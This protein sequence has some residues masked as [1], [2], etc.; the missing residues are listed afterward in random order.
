MSQLILILHILVAIAMIA[1]ILMQH[2]KGAD[3]GA[4]F[5]SG[6]SNTMFGSVGS[7]P[8]LMKITAVLAAIFFATSITLSYFISHKEQQPAS[9][10]N[11]PTPQTATPVPNA[12]PQKPN[13]NKAAVATPQVKSN[14][15]SAKTNAETPKTNEVT[16]SKIA[17][18]EPKE[19]PKE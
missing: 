4:T 7:M 13:T 10:F 2:G 14:V 6:S 12:K 19:A 16:K 15:E 3:A 9:L 18:P 17:A 5:G 1:L 11:M 8:F